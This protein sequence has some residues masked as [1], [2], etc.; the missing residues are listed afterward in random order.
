[1]RQPGIYTI[2][3][4]PRCVTGDNGKKS[5]LL[6]REMKEAFLEGAGLRLKADMHSNALHLKPIGVSYVGHK[7]PNPFLYGKL[8]SYFHMGKINKCLWGR[9]Y[10]AAVC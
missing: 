9:V 3:S 8:L 1:M 10:M 5:R 4:I 6:L 7:L 2:L